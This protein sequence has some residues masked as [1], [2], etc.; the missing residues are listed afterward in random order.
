MN[1]KG[2]MRKK[3]GITLISLVVT[4]IILLI[5]A[6][7]TIATITSD[8]GI[9]KNANDAKEQT[10]IAE[11]KEILECATIIAMGK[12][13]YGNIESENLNT[14]LKNLGAMNYVVG[15]KIDNAIPVIFEDKRKYFVDSEGN[16]IEAAKI[17]EGLEIGTQVSYTPSGVYT[18]QAEYASSDLAIVDEDGNYSTEN[19][20]EL[21]SS[22]SDFKITTW[23]V[24]KINEITGEIQLVPL[25]PTI[26]KV[27]LQGAQ[28][29]NNGVMLLNEACSNLYSSSEITARSI[30]ISDIESVM[31]E[32]KLKE[33]KEKFLNSSVLNEKGQLKNAISSSNK[34]YPIIYENEIKSVI[35]E[36]E[37][38]RGLGQSE[39]EELISRTKTSTKDST[40][41]AANGFL[42][43]SK[44]I[45]PYQT[46]Y[47]FASRNDFRSA[48]KDDYK[49]ILARGDVE[50]WIATRFVNN[51]ASTYC[52]YGI[53][54][55][56]GGKSSWNFMLCYS[57]KSTT[58]QNY[59]L[60]P[61][62]TLSYE[63]IGKDS[64]GFS[65][66]EVKNQNK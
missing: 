9:I 3:S 50:Y 1:F 30:N 54:A 6:G 33:A 35:D 17:P 4:I 38:E 23:I 45:R 52:G 37:N 51:C 53:A 64:T 25:N 48:L 57:S 44:S 46:F 2:K 21:D 24:F 13:K 22:T 15:E 19:N 16:I 10:K 14:E 36:S 11:E 28:G 56:Y 8:N 60:F 12:D 61:I 66:D 58:S 65:V 39:Q 18:W 27:R 62:V 42:T 31:D 5:L 20:I 34:N 59:S 7:I 41:N 26:G 32:E 63:L 40:Q 49:D 47:E 55:T 29:Y 43:A